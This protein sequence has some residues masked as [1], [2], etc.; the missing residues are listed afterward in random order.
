[1]RLATLGLLLLTLLPVAASAQTPPDI[2]VVGS[3][4]RTPRV[5]TSNFVL[6]EFRPAAFDE[7]TTKSFSYPKTNLVVNVGVDYN[8]A[9]NSKRKGMP[10]SVTVAIAVSDKGRDAFDS[11]DNAVARTGYGKK[12]AG[13]Y[14]EKQVVDGEAV[15]TFVVH[16]FRERRRK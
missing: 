1:M 5:T 14:V 7:R 13:L 3:S 8:E 15:Y 2:C 4:L 16:C 10:G 11:T 12:W 9:D 6:G